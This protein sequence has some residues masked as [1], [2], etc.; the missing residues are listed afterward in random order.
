MNMKHTP[1]L[2]GFGFVL[3]VG[4]NQA[5]ANGPQIPTNKIAPI[6][7]H[8]LKELKKQSLPIKQ[9]KALEDLKRMPRAEGVRLARADCSPPSTSDALV[10]G[11]FTRPTGGVPLGAV[12]AYAVYS[13]ITVEVQAITT[14]RTDSRVDFQV[15]DGTLGSR[16]GL[17]IAYTVNMRYGTSSTAASLANIRVPIRWRWNPHVSAVTTLSGARLMREGAGDIRVRLP[18]LRF[19]QVGS[20]AIRLRRAGRGDGLT[21]T[22]WRDVSH[23]DVGNFSYEGVLDAYFRRVPTAWQDSDP[24]TWSGTIEV[25]YSHDATDC[26]AG[27]RPT[28]SLSIPYSGTTPPPPSPLPD[29]RIT[30]AEQTLGSIKV[31]IT[32]IGTSRSGRT[33]VT[34][35]AT[36]YV[37]VIADIPEL[38][39]SESVTTDWIS[40]TGASGGRPS[41]FSVTVNPLPRSF[42]ESDYSNNSLSC[43]RTADPDSAW[44]CR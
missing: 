12:F 30:L 15:F 41:D 23:N 21:A 31:Q 11:S 13:D 2:L 40:V 32:N 8:Q 1:L 27:R 17:P 3:F 26:S 4:L 9:K 28:G 20:M 5:I 6:N 44:T 22:D 14:G 43:V 16:P 19:D 34:R 35:Q 39:P 42:S 10:V 38:A 25:A 37:P 18:N 7:P 36:G 29:L 33:Q 24:T